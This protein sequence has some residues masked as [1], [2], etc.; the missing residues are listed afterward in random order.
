MPRAEVVCRSPIPRAAARGAG[1]TLIEVLV[2]LAV[3]SVVLLGARA[4]VAAVTDAAERA[5][6]T[7][8]AMTR[9]IN[10][11]EALRGIVGRLEVGTPQSGTFAG[12]ESAAR[13]SSWCDVAAGWQERCLVLLEMMPSDGG[14][15]LVVITSTGDSLVVRRGFRYGALRYLASPESGGA[16]LSAWGPSITAP[17]AIGIV[18]DRDTLIVRIGERG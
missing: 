7:D 9:D 6:R 5:A 17:P 15:G 16:W 8:A 4:M 12:N 14:H 13:F 11:Q 18:L 3:S 1:F 10:A 2:A